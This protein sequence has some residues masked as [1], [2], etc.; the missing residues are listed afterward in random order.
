MMMKTFVYFWLVLFVHCGSV[1][2]ATKNGF[3]LSDALI[4]AEMIL[5]GGPPRDG[6]P[7]IDQPQFDTPADATWL[8]G[9]DRVLGVVVGGE[10]RAYPIRILNWHELVNDRVGTQ[11]FAVTYCPLCGSGVVFASNIGAG[12]LVFGIS[13]LLY[14]SDVLLF[15]RQTGSLWSQ[16]MQQ[17]ISGPLKGTKLPTI[18]VTHTTWAYWRKQHPDTQ[19]LNRK[20]GSKRRY[21]RS[22]YGDYDDSARL[23]FPV[24]NQAPRTYHPKERVLGV[25]VGDVHIAYPFVELARRQERTRNSMIEVEIEGHV[26]TLQF[27]I[28]SDTAVLFDKQG[29]LFPA[30]VLFWFAW[31]AFHPDTEVFRADE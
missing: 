2:A 12:H 16:L 8:Q 29:E 17:S 18:P 15:D 1:G 21:S 30:T 22:P 28:E 23:S 10:P 26:F 13:G 24:T 14:N 4:P 20:T 27:H 5:R 19:V 6:I 25:T 9:D 3:A 7:A 31:F 11:H